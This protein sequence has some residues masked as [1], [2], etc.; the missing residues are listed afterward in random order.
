[1]RLESVR[2]LKAELLARPPEAGV[3][4]APGAGVA[5]GV[6]PA[7]G[8]DFRRVGVVGRIHRRSL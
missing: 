8:G 1:M 6:H 7:G 2:D 3:R 5:L 4:G